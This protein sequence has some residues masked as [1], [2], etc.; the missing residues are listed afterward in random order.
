MSGCMLL[1]RGLLMCGTDICYV[2]GLVQNVFHF[3]RHRDQGTGTGTAYTPMRCAVLITYAAMRCACRA[4]A[5]D[6]HS[7][8]C[9]AERGTGTA[10]APMRG[11]VPSMPYSAK[12]N[13]RN[14]IPGTNCTD[15]AVCCI[16]SWS[17]QLPYAISGTE[18]A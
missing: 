13:I 16:R 12:S 11:A 6:S 9:Y 4:P 15:I 7:G 2:L 8:T 3:F 14:R 1:R 18:T 5:T 10:Y 17:V